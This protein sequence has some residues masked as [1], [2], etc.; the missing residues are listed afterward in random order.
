M[1]LE[2]VDALSSDYVPDLGRV[3]KGTRHDLITLRI[4]VK[5]YNFSLMTI[6]AK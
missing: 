2:S 1:A 6:Q 4:E 3:V 5:G